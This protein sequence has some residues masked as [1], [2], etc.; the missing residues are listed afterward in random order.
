MRFQAFCPPQYP[1]LF[2]H[3][4]GTLFFQ[5]NSGNNVTGLW[6]SDWT[7]TGTV[8]VKEINDGTMYCHLNS[9]TDVNGTLF[10]TAYYGNSDYELWKSDGTAAGTMLVKG[11]M[12]AYLSSLTNVNGTLFFSASYYN[13]QYG[14][15]K[16]D[17]T[18]DGTV[19]V[20]DFIAGAGGT[21]PQYL[22]DVGGTLFFSAT[23]STNGTELWRSDGT[24][25]G[26]VLVKD[27]FPGSDKA[28]PVFLTQYNNLL[29]F[30]ANN[31]VHGEE[32][33]QSDGTPE[34]TVMAA[35]IYPGSGGS[36][37]QNLYVSGGALYFRAYT[38]EYGVGFWKLTTTAL[39]ILP[40]SHDFGTVAMNGNSSPQIVT[41]NNTEKT[42][43]NISSIQLTGTGSSHF[44][45]DSGNGT[46]GTCGNTPILNYGQSCTVSV[47][48][49]PK[50]NGIFSAKL[51]VTSN[52][53]QNPTLETT[54]TGS[55]PLY[56]LTTTINGSGS[57]T[58]TSAGS[59]DLICSAGNCTQ[60]YYS[61][62]TISL[63]PAAVGGYTF[64]GWSGACSGM[65]G[66]QVIMDG[67]E[68]VTATFQ[69]SGNVTMNGA[70]CIGDALSVLQASVG[71]KTLTAQ[72]QTLADVA[73]LDTVTGKP[74]GNG[75]V[76][77]GDALL[78]L[79]RVI[80]LASW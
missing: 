9:F 24:E 28:N 27:I 67:V 79:R 4:N 35:D 22:T 10:F 49:A 77:I 39:T 15:W 75:M 16:S 12:P 48:F 25:A 5:N 73:P 53:R 36:S 33:W 2:A 1:A 52:D 8:L 46:S 60:N 68:S 29:Y 78:I 64:V 50:S 6:K 61:G 41:L 26:T 31:G 62:T 20:K 65:G 30:V 63:S 47:F 55:T 19:L 23:D 72:E 38:Q 34:G 58:A 51:R 40:A 11:V 70:V 71:I 69:I 66:C 3:I 17:G 14:L 74:K 18:I 42:T 32:L 54:L 7:E 45:L 21:G 80:G 37:P 44:T 57:I 59:G 76:D 56:L 43:L 13:Y